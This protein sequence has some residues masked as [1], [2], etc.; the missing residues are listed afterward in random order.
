MQVFKS[1][2]YLLF[3]I[4]LLCY[5]KMTGL[6]QT[7]AETSIQLINSI[8]SIAWCVAIAVASG[9]LMSLSAMQTVWNTDEHWCDQ[10]KFQLF[11]FFIQFS[12]VFG[13][14]LFVQFCISDTLACC[15]RASWTVPPSEAA[16][17]ELVE[18]LL[19]LDFGHG[20]SQPCDLI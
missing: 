17:V 5:S 13:L 4:I 1:T 2:E 19:Q 3:S 20:D 18:V 8:C 7:V 9:S 16:L 11:S 15:S 12:I 6:L 14:F 10:A